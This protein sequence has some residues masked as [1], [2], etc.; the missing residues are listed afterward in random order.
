[1]NLTITLTGI[2]ILLIIA[3]IV[4]VKSIRKSEFQKN[5][6]SGHKCLFK[7]NDCWV[8]GRITALIDD[9]VII[10]DEEGDAYSRKRKHIR[11]YSN[12]R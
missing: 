10:E 4:L 3:V 6:R 2:I 9:D 11:P 5:M 1:M 8:K 12:L 7:L